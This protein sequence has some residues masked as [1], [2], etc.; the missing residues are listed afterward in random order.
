MR[1]SVLAFSSPGTPRLSHLPSVPRPKDRLARAR[2]RNAPLSTRG[3]PSRGIDRPC[4]GRWSGLRAEAGLRLA[5][6]GHMSRPCVV[7][8]AAC[9]TST[10]P[11]PSRRIEPC[12]TERPLPAYGLPHRQAPGDAPFR[13]LS[14][15]SLRWMLRCSPRSTRPEGSSHKGA[16][17]AGTRTL[18]LHKTTAERPP[19]LPLE[20]K[21]AGAWQPK[22]AHGGA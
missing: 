22:A 11:F 8:A 6:A 13:T 15:L 7:P 18:V 4:A 5:Q 16:P 10:T 20:R 17:A 9:C 3:S 2:P 14:G 21:S 1:Q 19:R 12:S